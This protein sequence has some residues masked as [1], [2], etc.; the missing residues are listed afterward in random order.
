MLSACIVPDPQTRHICTFSQQE[1]WR[2]FLLLNANGSLKQNALAQAPGT[3]FA[4]YA[5]ITHDLPEK[6]AIDKQQ[7]SQSNKKEN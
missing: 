3:L 4:R 7:H 6:D 1:F 2:A 5:V